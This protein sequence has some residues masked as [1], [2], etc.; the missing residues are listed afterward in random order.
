M[1]LIKNRLKK[2]DC[3]KR[4]YVLEDFPRNRIQAISLQTHGILLKHLGRSHE[5]KDPEHV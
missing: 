4:G 3:I 1:D 5:D 2:K